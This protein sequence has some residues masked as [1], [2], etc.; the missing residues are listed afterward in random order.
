MSMKKSA[1]SLFIV[2]ALALMAQKSQAIPNQIGGVGFVNPAGMRFENF[3]AL[4]KTWQAKSKL[5]GDWQDW[6]DPAVK[7]SGIL[8]Y[9]LD[10][11]ADV[12]GIT[13]SRVVAQIKNDQVLLFKIVFEKNS[14]Q[15]KALINQVTTNVQSFTGKNSEPGQRSF[16]YKKINIRITETSNGAVIVIIKPQTT[17]V[18]SR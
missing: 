9:R 8:L 12:F 11:R 15:A 7:D 2:L 17:T 16:S 10:M 13:A 5:P 4:G 14:S 3:A 6:Q 1:T 18:S